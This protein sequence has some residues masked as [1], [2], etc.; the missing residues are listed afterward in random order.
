MAFGEKVIKLLGQ[1]VYWGACALLSALV[2][3]S[4]FQVGI[5]GHPPS[6]IREVVDGTSHKPFVYRRLVPATIQQIEKII[7]HS[8]KEQMLRLADT[9]LLKEAFL[10]YRWESEH[11]VIY[12]SSAGLLFR[13]FTE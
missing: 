13:L 6:M 5:N 12:F 2:L 9:P 4:F 10:R 3:G 11:A 1:G 8:V 7:P